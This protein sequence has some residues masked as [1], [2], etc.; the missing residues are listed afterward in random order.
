VHFP[1]KLA[2]RTSKTSTVVAGVEETAA[3]PSKIKVKIHHCVFVIVV[4][5]G[6]NDALTLLDLNSAYTTQQQITV[7]NMLQYGP[8]CS[9]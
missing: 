5:L 2:K 6:Y 7:Y 8:F 4:V 9:R 1:S 3:Q